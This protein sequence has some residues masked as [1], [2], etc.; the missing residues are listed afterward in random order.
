MEMTNINTNKKWS[1]RVDT[2]KWASMVDSKKWASMVDS[3]KWATF[4]PR[5]SSKKEA[6]LYPSK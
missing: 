6:G 5:V 1:S 4:Q 3:K 2:K